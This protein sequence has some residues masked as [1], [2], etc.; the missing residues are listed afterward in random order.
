[1]EHGS[2]NLTGGL[3][4]QGETHTQTAGTQATACQFSEIE[5]QLQIKGASSV[6][7]C[8]PCG[9]ANHRPRGRVSCMQPPPVPLNATVCTPMAMSV[10]LGCEPST[11]TEIP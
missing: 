11:H 6:A 3:K 7:S 1:M 2:A 8:C 10:A 5:D 9:V 4:Q